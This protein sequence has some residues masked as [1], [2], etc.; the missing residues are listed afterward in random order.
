[1]NPQETQ[2]YIGVGP[3]EVATGNRG[4]EL[5][6]VYRMDGD[7]TLLQS[8]NCPQ[9]YPRRG[10]IMG[11]ESMTGAVEGDVEYFCKQVM[12]QVERYG[13]GG[14]SC[15]FP[16]DGKGAVISVV[17]QL[18]K[19]CRGKG[20]DFLVPEEFG[21]VVQWGKIFISTALS[22]GTLEGRFKTAMETYGARRVVMD[23]ECMGEDF[24]L[25]APRGCGEA[26]TR[27][28]IRQRI[29][30]EQANVFFSQELCARYFTYQNRE[31][32]L[33]FVLFDDE[34]TVREK[35]ANS[36]RWGLGGV[37]VTQQQVRGW[38]LWGVI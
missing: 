37:A 17:Q 9:N 36:K 26:V 2:V 19:E 11:I 20:L 24:L 3:R 29:Q 12:G 34:G 30:R 31:N 35:I 4:V 21:D 22:G 8:G 18:E 27:E 6:L 25:P 1:M 16:Y 38:K 14:V 32:S 15:L 5:Q 28:E 23:I 33:R 10:Q 7:L 13:Y